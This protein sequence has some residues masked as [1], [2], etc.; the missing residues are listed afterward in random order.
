MK[1]RVGCYNIIYKKE[2]GK[3]FFL[4]V[5][6]LDNYKG[7][8]GGGLKEG[9]SQIKG[10]ARELKEEAGITKKDILSYKKIKETEIF[11]MPNGRRKEWPE[12]EENHYFFIV[13]VKPSVSLKVSDEHEKLIWV[14]AK[15]TKNIFPWPKRQE[16]LD[17]AVKEIL[18]VD[19]NAPCSPPA[20][21]VR[22]R[23]AR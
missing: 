9:E 15:E 5:R 14:G 21:F 6:Y 13:K 16:I 3:I 17:K 20:H 11:V 12:H 10:W 18:E 22:L 7:L 23:A 1:K 4:L 2:K 19:G 8:V